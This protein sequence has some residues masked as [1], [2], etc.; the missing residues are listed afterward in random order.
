ME[1]SGKVSCYCTPGCH[2]LVKDKV[3]FYIVTKAILAVAVQYKYRY[4]IM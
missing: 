3:P 1:L 4:G 2:S